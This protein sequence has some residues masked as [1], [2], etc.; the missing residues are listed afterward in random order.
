MKNGKIV[1]DTITGKI[2]LA[3]TAQ[4]CLRCHHLQLELN[5]LTKLLMRVN[6]DN[7]K[8]HQQ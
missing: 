3:R 6:E 5:K 4:H 2:S 8:Y 1:V 7:K